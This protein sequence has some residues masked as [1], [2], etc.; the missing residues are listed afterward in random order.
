VQ[1]ETRPCT[2][3]GST[4]PRLAPDRAPCQEGETD[5]LAKPQPHLFAFHALWHQMDV[6]LER[7]HAKYVED[8]MSTMEFAGTMI[9]AAVA[10]LMD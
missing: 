4:S 5:Q 2:A 10:L 9:R 7:F 6:H 8:P 3:T 1:W